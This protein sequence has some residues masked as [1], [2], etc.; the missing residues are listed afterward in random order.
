MSSWPVKP[1]HCTPFPTQ[2]L[3]GSL[4][5][6]Q[7]SSEAASPKPHYYICSATHPDTHA[8]WCH[9]CTTHVQL[10]TPCHT[11]HMGTHTHACT[12]VHILTLI[13]KCTLTRGQSKKIIT[14]QRGIDCLLPSASK[15]GLEWDE[16]RA[17]SRVLVPS[18]VLAPVPTLQVEAPCCLPCSSL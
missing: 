7:V 14:L 6:N 2:R 15:Y 18:A 4:V 17:S 8:T 3:L 1:G 12:Q 16:Q 11:H 9:T 10:H 5:L 13:Y